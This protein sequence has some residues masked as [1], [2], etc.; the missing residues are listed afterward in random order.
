MNKARLDVA[1]KFAAEADKAERYLS[2]IRHEVAAACAA[3]TDGSALLRQ[4]DWHREELVKWATLK[5][6][7]LAAADWAGNMSSLSTPMWISRVELMKF[8][9]KEDQDRLARWIRDGRRS[10]DIQRM[11]LELEV[12]REAYAAVTEATEEA[13][14]QDEIDNITVIEEGN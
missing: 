12:K 14:Q 2:T 8:E 13:E 7:Y 3:D 6:Q 11:S 9:L 5:K 1:D 4:F 10:E